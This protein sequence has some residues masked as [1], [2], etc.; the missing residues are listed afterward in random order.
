MFYDKTLFEAEEQ[1]RRERQETDEQHSPMCLV[2]HFFCTKANLLMPLT[3]LEADRRKVGLS[4][5]FQPWHHPCFSER[6]FGT[7][8][9]V[10]VC[11]CMRPLRSWWT[12][13]PSTVIT[14]QKPTAHPI[15]K[16]TLVSLRRFSLSF[17]SNEEWLV[18]SLRLK[19]DCF[20]ALQCPSCSAPFED[21]SLIVSPT[22]S[23][24]GSNYVF[25]LSKLKN[26]IK[27]GFLSSLPGPAR[28]ARVSSEATSSSKFDKAS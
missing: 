26:K 17:F 1:R 22:S 20:A 19:T 2:T 9:I 15:R 18:L 13:V 14:L 25:D 27:L 6:R 4:F 28:L 11:P 23:P 8:T 12:A 16:K 5:L 21:C 3:A 10:S 7:C 24:A